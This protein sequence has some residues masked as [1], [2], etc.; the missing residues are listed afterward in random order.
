MPQG[1]F[2][3]SPPIYAKQSP[4]LFVDFFEMIVFSGVKLK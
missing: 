4:R 3:V 2:V 1:L